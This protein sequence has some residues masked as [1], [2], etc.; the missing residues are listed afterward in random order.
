M[1]IGTHYTMGVSKLGNL[2]HISPVNE[3]ML[4]M[5][6]KTPTHSIMDAL[7]QRSKG[8]TQVRRKFTEIFF[9]LMVWD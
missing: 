5:C 1:W 9:N 6:F 4:E 7:S 8:I 2:V 3:H